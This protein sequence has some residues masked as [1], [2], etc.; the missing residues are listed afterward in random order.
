MVRVAGRPILER[1]VLHL[2]GCGVQR[3][4]LAVNYK[5]DVIEAHFGD[6]SSLGCPIEYLREDRPLGTGG[7]LSLLPERPADPVVVLNGDLLTQ[8]DVG[9]MV[10]FHAEQRSKVTVGF[11][12]Y[13]HTVPFGVLDVAAERVVGMREKPSFNWQTNAGIY[14]LDPDL[15]ARIPADVPFPLP[16]LIEEC[17]ARGE[18]VGAFRVDEEWMDVG[19]HDELRKARGERGQP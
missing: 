6:G 15:I 14:V 5:A 16:A 1:I 4:F 3:I 12:E 2:V 11:H 8:A 7:A 10:A 9:G 13:V 19:H 18:A 17:L